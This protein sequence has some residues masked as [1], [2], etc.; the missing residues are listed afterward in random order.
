[1]CPNINAFVMQGTERTKS[2]LPGEKVNSIAPA[3]ELIVDLVVVS[4]FPSS[5]EWLRFKVIRWSCFRVDT[6]QRLFPQ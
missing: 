5:N 4:L 2:V 3:Y 6:F 1:M